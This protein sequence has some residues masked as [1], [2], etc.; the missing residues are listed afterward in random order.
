MTR[1]E[2]LLICAVALGALVFV[3]LAG[4]CMA[5]AQPWTPEAVNSAS[6]PG[7]CP[8][9][10]GGKEGVVWPVEQGKKL[11]AATKATSVETVVGLLP[12]IAPD[13][14]DRQAR[15]SSMKATISAQDTE[16]A[17]LRSAIAAKDV[18]VA[19]ERSAS[20]SL[21]RALQKTTE[22]LRSVRD[23]D[24]WWLTTLKWVGV[25]A[26]VVGMSFGIASAMRY[27]TPTTK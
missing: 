1:L 8:T 19:A 23:G 4:P 5:V 11:H 22:A 25:G 15:E 24:P 7:N 3:L 12:N 16:R 14:Q 2:L 13:W 21:N 18:Q 10:L 27:S 26:M 20:D 6:K 17:A 9:C